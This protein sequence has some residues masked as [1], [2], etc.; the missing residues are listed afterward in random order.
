ML[1]LPLLRSFCG[2]SRHFFLL[3]FQVHLL[4]ALV[5]DLTAEASAPVDRLAGA[6][7]AVSKAELGERIQQQSNFEMQADELKARVARVRTHASK[8]V[9]N[10]RHTSKVRCVRV[11]GDFIDRFTP[12]VIAAARALAGRIYELTE[13]VT[14][15]LVSNLTL[16]F[17]RLLAPFYR[18]SPGDGVNFSAL[19]WINSGIFRR[20]MM[21][22]RQQEA[23]CSK[24]G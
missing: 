3:A 10:S 12:Q 18:L 22:A 6:A 15:S 1:M 24:H 19:A 13:L 23:G 21:A 2:S 5:D 4:T 16:Q 7:L 20:E 17:L 8:A 11:T 9:E 14:F